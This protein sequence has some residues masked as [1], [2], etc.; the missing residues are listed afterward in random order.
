MQAGFVA[1]ALVFA[2][3]SSVSS[4]VAAADVPCALATG[5]SL[6]VARVVD[7]ETLLLDDGREVRLVGA[8][9][10]K[11]DVLSVALDSW[12]TARE[13][14][15]ALEA[16]VA[17]R[18]VTLRYEGRRRDR[19]GRVLAQAFAVTPGADPTWIQEHLIRAGHA[20]AYALPGNA[21]CIRALIAAEERARVERRG[22]WA[23]PSY[24]VGAASDAD[25]LL[26][27]AGRFALV[28]GRVAQVTHA[29]RTTYL[30]FGAD[31][32]RDFTASIAGSVVARRDGG[33]AQLSAMAGKTVRVR[34]WIERRNGPMIVLGSLD[35]IEVLDES[36]EASQR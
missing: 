14:A 5:E 6:G 21:G 13:T 12:P 8:L 11:P 9:A 10:P 19:Y 15:R 35:E 30:N 25:A 2:V 3:A 32:R 24:G 27:L 26:K 18:T 16:L 31:W 1:C 23:H 7:G 20:R 17:G 22:L 29:Q 28:E 36:A 33:A 4:P 34:G